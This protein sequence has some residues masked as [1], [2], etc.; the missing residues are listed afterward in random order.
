MK[1]LF[2]GGVHPKYN[3]EMS[4]RSAG[5][6]SVSPDYAVIPLKQHIGAQCKPLVKVGDQVS[7][8]QKIGD[9]D[10]FCVPVHASVSGKITAIEPRP[11]PSGDM[12]EAI[13]IENDF[14]DTTI[15]YKTCDIPTEQLDSDT[16]LHT[17]REAGIVG[18]G[19]AAFPGSIKALS[20]MGNIDT[21]I[22]NACECEPYITA[23]D[24]LL[25]TS[26]R[27]VLEGMMIIDH[28]L[29]PDRLILAIE[30][31]KAEAIKIIREVKKDYPKLE[32]KVLPT[33][34]PQ[35]SEKQLIQSLTGRQVPPKGLPFD[36]D[37]IVFNVSTFAA[38]F[39]A[40]RLG[41]PLIQRIVTVTGEG[42]AD[43]RNFIVKIGTPFEAVIEKAGGLR[44]KA[45]RVISGGPMMGV[46]QR[47]LSVP[48]VK[49]TSAILCLPENKNDYSE[50]PVCL[51]CGKCVEVCPM[52][53]EPLYLYRF[54]LAEYRDELERFNLVDCMECGSCAYICPGKLPL[55]EKFRIGKKLMKGDLQK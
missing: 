21:V 34:Y 36:V 19:G 49:A 38:I 33:K 7:I 41:T 51:R 15:Q 48:V 35:G 43:P 44:D 37:C 47:N 30:D 14:K 31:N 32:I 20:A 22:A 46:A 2:F 8:G 10:G 12:V 5:L 27:E 9:G 26:P 53:L 54:T 4:T 11:H 13:V 24:L 29:S 55:V 6:I 23:D 28:I 17:I 50:N 25:R 45:E 18:M 40:V 39:R 16:V 42:I 52:H 1:R 3:K